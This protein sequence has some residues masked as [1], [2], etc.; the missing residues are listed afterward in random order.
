VGSRDPFGGRALEEPFVVIFAANA[1]LYEC[2]AAPLKIL[3]YLLFINLSSSG[4]FTPPFGFNTNRKK[5]LN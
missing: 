5:K 3:K 4:N 1:S 2:D